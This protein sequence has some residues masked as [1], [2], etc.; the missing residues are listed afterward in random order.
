MLTLF[1]LKWLLEHLNLL[2]RPE[3]CPRVGPTV[4]VPGSIR[5]KFEDRV[6]LTLFYLHLRTFGDLNTIKQYDVIH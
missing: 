4:L 1:E 3:V 2:L 6:S 5:H